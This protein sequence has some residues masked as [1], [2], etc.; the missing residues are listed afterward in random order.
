MIAVF[1]LA[2]IAYMLST[3]AYIAYLFLQRQSLQVAASVLLAAGFAC[4]TFTIAWDLVATGHFP[5][6]NMHETLS[7]VAWT[8][9]AAFFLL[10]LRFRL[11]VLGVYAAPLAAFLLLVAYSFPSEPMADPRLLKG[12]WLVMHVITIFLGDAVFALA[13]GI[14]G[15]YLLQEHGIKRKKRGFFFSRLPSLDLLDSTGY[16]CIFTGFTLLTVG[17]IAGMLYAN[18]VLGRFWGW[19]PKEVWSAVAWVFYALLLHLRL[20][21]GWR[22]RRAAILS[23]AGFGVLLFTFIGVNLL[24]KGYHGQFTQF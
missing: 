17:M 3:A 5:A 10:Q 6:N 21:K 18:N 2:L 24:M 8:L 14:G 22:G 11:K 13:A 4:Q 19:D 1:I 7:V 16:A 23:I 12:F 20:I 9:V 15:L